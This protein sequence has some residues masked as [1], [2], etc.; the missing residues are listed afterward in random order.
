MTDPIN[1]QIAVG[2]THVSALWNI[3]AEP[4]A[5]L[6]LAHGAGAGM[7]HSFLASVAAG[8]HRR[9]VACL[10]YQFPFSERG[11]RRP[12][13]P[14][15]CHTAVNAALTEAARRLPSIP[16]FAGGK[17]FGGRMTSQTVALGAAAHLHGLVFF[18]FPLHPAD[19]PSDARGAHLK[20]VPF[21]MLFIQGTRD[22]LAEN[23]LL[24]AVLDKLPLATLCT[25]DQADH[26]FHVPVKSGKTDLKV[27]DEMLDAS[28]EW[29]LP[30]QRART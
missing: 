22:A 21:P 9:N 6:V 29:M 7:T 5:C 2:D 18:G 24:T 4:R 16:L 1:C 25:I 17:S 8:L 12:D 3:P 10:R 26:S 15:V 30:M 13:P 14:K 28:V 19:K 23:H 20:D 27:L 11:S